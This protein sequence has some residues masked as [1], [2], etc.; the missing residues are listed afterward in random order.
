MKT[1]SDKEVF[2]S[3]WPHIESEEF[4]ERLI[5]MDTSSGVGRV[6]SFFYIILGGRRHP[7]KA[8]R[9]GRA[10]GAN[11]RI[12]DDLLDGDGCSPVDNRERFLQN[13]IKSVK[14]GKISE[15]VD[16]EDEKVAYYAGKVLFNFYKEYPEA[17]ESIIQTLNSMKN[18]VIDEDKKQ[19][20]TYLNYVDAAGGD[21]GVLILE[22]IQILPDFEINQ[23]KKEFVR[24]FSK[25]GQ[26][27]DDI[28]DGD[29]ELE[30]ADIEKVY[31][32]KLEE[33]QEHRDTLLKFLA[34]W[35]MK[36]INIIRYLGS[37]KIIQ[38]KWNKIRGRSYGRS[39]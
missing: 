12:V 9:L 27:A 15:P 24:A 13:Y 19:K 37:A 38:R 6:T 14:Q 34:C 7:I 28:F 16:E 2:Q 20:K 1:I 17:H 39:T 4:R 5:Y 26:I 18:K 10:L 33:L 31:E 25:A 30:D 11:T 22:V 3:V 23:S 32:E 21:H 8:S 35:S 36:N 29:T